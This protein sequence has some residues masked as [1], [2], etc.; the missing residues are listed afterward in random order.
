M[1]SPG[2]MYLHD[3]KYSTRIRIGTNP[4]QH[5]SDASAASLNN[6]GMPLHVPEGYWA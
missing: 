6:G 3:G 1:S 4:L 2:S 5:S